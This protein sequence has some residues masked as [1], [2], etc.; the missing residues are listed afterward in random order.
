MKRYEVETIAT[1]YCYDL[2]TGE[3]INP[4]PEWCRKLQVALDRSFRE[5]VEAINHGMNNQ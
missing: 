2:E 5:H 1:G 3:I 4:P